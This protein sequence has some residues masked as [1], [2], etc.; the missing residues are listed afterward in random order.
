MFS[1]KHILTFLF[2]LILFGRLAA[3][4][5]DS[6]YVLTAVIY[7][8][9]YRPVPACHVINLKSRQ[10]STSDTLGIF[11]IPV[12]GSDT[13]LIRNIA[14]K[15]VLVKADELLRLRSIRLIRM[16][17]PLPEARVFP[18]GA[19]YSDF[20]EAMLSMSNQQSLGEKF[21]LPR[22]DPNY[23]P[24]AMNE[25][26]VKSAGLLFTSP[27]SFFYYNFSKR[28]KSERRAYWLE[29]NWENEEA[30]Q[31]LLSSENLAPITGLSGEELSRFQ[32]FLF[33]KMD[34]DSKC[35]ELEVYSEIHALWDMYRELKERNMLEE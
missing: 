12:S 21:G 4:E 17:Y 26:E 16:S 23:V 8:E 27:V 20:S 28:A 1:V 10:G 31:Q 6:A 25:K 15:D 5:T 7:D 3:Q 9:S 35:T 11:S 34:C 14:Y 2:F 19:S 33:R 24:W 22:Q 30:F 13:L 32:N 18:W 29:K